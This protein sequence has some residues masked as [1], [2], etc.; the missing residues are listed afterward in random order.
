MC[1]QAA[2]DSILCLDRSFVRFWLRLPVALGV[3]TQGVEV[4]VLDRW[5][6]NF[7]R[8]FSGPRIT[9]VCRVPHVELQASIRRLLSETTRTTQHQPFFLPEPT[10]DSQKVWF[11]ERSAARECPI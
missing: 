11:R 4:G 3:L 5:K 1:T 6:T 10:T 7:R 8:L 2:S 9:T